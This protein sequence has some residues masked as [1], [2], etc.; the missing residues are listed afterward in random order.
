MRKIAPIGK[1]SYAGKKFKSVGPNELSASDKNFVRNNINKYTVQ[2]LANRVGKGIEVLEKFFKKE[3]L[4]QVLEI[5]NAPTPYIEVASEFIEAKSAATDV[6]KTNKEPKTKLP[7][8]KPQKEL[9]VEPL[10][11]PK[12]KPPKVPKVKLPKEPKVKPPKE[13][14]VK[15]PK[16][17]KVKLPKEP[18][19][20][21]PKEPKE[22]KKRGPK[23]SDAV[24]KKIAFIKENHQKFPILVLAKALNLS[25]SAIKY[26]LV[27]LGLK[28]RKKGLPPSDEQSEILNF[29]KGN[30]KAYKIS[31]LAEFFKI[32]EPLVI[33]FLEKIN[34]EPTKRREIREESPEI[35]DFLRNNYRTMTAMEMSKALGI[36]QNRVR[37]VCEKKGFLR[38]PE[39][40][41]AIRNRFNKII[42]TADEEAYMLANHGKITLGEIA[43][44][45]Q[46]T[47]SSVVQFFTKKGMKITKNQQDELSTQNLK[48]YFKKVEEEKNLARLGNR[49]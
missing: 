9:K 33:Y 6:L 11:V 24:A 7:K 31:D 43:K 4:V 29:L 23:L 1:R 49:N 41:A 15:P 44:K 25:V 28:A 14:K 19:V 12:V 40:V 16:E 45:I 32:P 34:V 5:Q 27:N 35:V 47:R 38:T 3:K 18:K 26:Y 20:K 46:H 17:P 2:Q 37:Y 13:P 39:E 42:F 22:W 21:L 36:V 48:D 10:K 30:R 8:V